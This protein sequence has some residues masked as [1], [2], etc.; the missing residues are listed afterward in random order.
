MGLGLVFPRFQFQGILYKWWLVL[1][2]MSSIKGGLMGASS[3]TAGLIVICAGGPLSSISIGI[4][5]A[6]STIKILS[7][8]IA[9]VAS[10]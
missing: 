1:F 8:W 6:G 5:C 9:F 3:V 4:D 7:V 2:L 10:Q